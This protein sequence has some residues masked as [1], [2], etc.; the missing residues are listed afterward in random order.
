VTIADAR[1]ISFTTFRRSGEAVATPVW[2]APFPDGRVGFTTKVPSGKVKRLAHTPRVV[3]QPSD[4]RGRVADDAPSYE[5][6]AV[7]VSE[8]A[9]YEA[10]VAALQRKYGIQFRAVHLGSMIRRR[11]GR[12]DNAVVVVTVA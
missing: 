2:V 5:G 10:G 7:V 11:I 4:A 12:G 6:T 8:G 1:Y 3:L 9:D